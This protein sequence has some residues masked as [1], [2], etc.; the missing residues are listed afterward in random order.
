MSGVAVCFDFDTT[1]HAA[2][3]A[4]HGCHLPSQAIGSSSSTRYVQRALELRSAELT[5]LK[6]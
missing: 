2:R 1:D 6:A 5:M 3:E 4:C